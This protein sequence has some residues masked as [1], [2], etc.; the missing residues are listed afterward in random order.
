MLISEKQQPLPT[1]HGSTYSYCFTSKAAK[2]HQTQ[3]LNAVASQ[4]T[5]GGKHRFYHSDPWSFNT[6]TA[7][8]Y[9]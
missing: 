9:L 8:A 2:H 1:V 3:N 4:I 6:S 5:Q 7:V